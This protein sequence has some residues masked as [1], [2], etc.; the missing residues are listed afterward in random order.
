MQHAIIDDDHLGVVAHRSSAVRETVTPLEEP[1]FQ[2]PQC[3][4]A[5]AVGVGDQRANGHPRATARLERTGDL[6][7]VQAKIMISIVFFAR[8]IAVM[9]GVIPA[10]GWTINF[11]FVPHIGASRR[12]SHSEEGMLSWAS[13]DRT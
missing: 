5:A 4:R 11:I 3:L 2:F 8:L 1:Q 10:S 6:R 13:S 9:T 12:L 7:P